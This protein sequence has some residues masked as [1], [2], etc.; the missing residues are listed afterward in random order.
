MYLLEWRLYI[1]IGVVV[2]F[3]MAAVI[4]YRKYDRDWSAM[5]T[6][7]VLATL[8]LVWCTETFI[9]HRPMTLSRYLIGISPLV[10]IGI[11]LGLEKMGQTGSAL[12]IVLMSVVISFWGFYAVSRARID[13][14]LARYAEYIRGNSSTNEI[15]VHTDTFFYLPLKYY[16]LPDRQNYLAYI[17]TRHDYAFL[18]TDIPEIGHHLLRTRADFDKYLSATFMLVDPA[19]VLSKEQITT[20]GKKEFINYWETRYQR[21]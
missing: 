7:L 9:A 5:V 3:L 13:P 21:R 11:W 19:N 18:D 15:V 16:Y 2:L 17:P 20:V 12:K 4:I 1:G 8:L 6:G 14:G 10:Y